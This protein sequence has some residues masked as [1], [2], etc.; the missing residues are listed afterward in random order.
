VLNKLRTVFSSAPTVEYLDNQDGLLA[1]R[2][3]KWLGFDCTSVKLKTSFG[4]VLAEVRVDSYDPEREVY[5]L[6]VIDQKSFP[7]E[8]KIERRRHERLEKVVRVTSQFFPE[9]TATTVDISLSGLRVV[10][11]G[12]LEAG[13][14][15][16]VTIELDDSGTPPLSIRA[17]V[18]WSAVKMNGRFQSGLKITAMHPKTEQI[19]RRY[20][21]TRLAI[22]KKLHTLEDVDPFE[23]M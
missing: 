17:F 18:A 16:P 22:E 4:T 10:T 1:V 12:P 15:I 2:S 19:I 6:Q 8:L 20:I 13:Q 14:E 3:K 23:V 11:R 9:F 5:R 21:Q 7:K